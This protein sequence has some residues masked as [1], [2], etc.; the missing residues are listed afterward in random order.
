MLDDV[1]LLQ[2]APAL[3]LKLR[4]EG[5]SAERTTLAA[6]PCTCVR[7]GVA[8]IDCRSYRGRGVLG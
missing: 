1:V 5:S 4:D 2:P 7:N 8:E 6:W 3:A